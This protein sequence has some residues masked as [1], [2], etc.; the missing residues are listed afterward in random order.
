MT[1]SFLLSSKVQM[2]TFYQLRMS[3][4][5]M[6]ASTT[7]LAGGITEWADHKLLVQKDACTGASPAGIALYQLK[8]H[9]HRSGWIASGFMGEQSRPDKRKIFLFPPP[10]KV[11]VWN[12]PCCIVCLA[13]EKNISEKKPEAPV[14]AADVMYSYFWIVQEKNSNIYFRLPNYFA[15]NSK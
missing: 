3:T 6:K 15:N 13:E 4:L 8:A 9:F 11:H 2:S 5:M 12:K 7:V 1:T 14:R 10:F